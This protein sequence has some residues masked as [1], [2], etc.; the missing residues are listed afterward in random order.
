MAQFPQLVAVH[1]KNYFDFARLSIV[2][3]AFPGGY[4]ESLQGRTGGNSQHADFRGEILT[5]QKKAS[6]AP[7]EEVLAE[8]RIR[9][10][11]DA[12]IDQIAAGE[13]VERPASVV[14]ELV[15]NALDA[16]A[17]RIRVELREG[18]NDFIAV[19]DDGLGMAADE[20]RM[21]LRRHATSKIA[22]LDDLERIGSFG[23][24]GEAL[25]A[26]AS[27]SRMRLLSRRRDADVGHEL[28]IEAGEVTRDREAGCPV[29]T[30]IEVA[31]LFGQI[32]ARRKFLKKPATEWG[33]AYDW[34]M[35]LALSLPGV[36]FEVIREDREVGVWPATSDPFAR[37]GAVLGNELAS[38]LLPVNWEERAGHI[39]AWVSSPDL[40]RA[41]AQSLYLYV[42]GRPV[43]DRL[44]RHA[45]LE[46]YR[47]WLPRGRYPVVVLALTVDP[48]EVDVNV[49]P[50]KWEVRFTQP[51]AIHALVRQAIR[52][53]M[54][55]RD[56]LISG[57]PS[58]DHDS[59][60]SGRNSGS[61]GPIRGES[62]SPRTSAWVA[63]GAS[64]RPS[65]GRT[66][67][68]FAG[69]RGSNTTDQEAEARAN[70]GDPL[71]GGLAL[72][73]LPLLGQMLASYLLLEAEDGLILVDQHAAH[74][75][76]LYERLRSSWLDGSVSR[77]GLLM[78]V[79]VE[80]DPLAVAALEDERELVLGL[81]FEVEPFGEGAV[82]VRAIPALL[83]GQ[84]P[85]QLIQDLA[86][87]LSSSE[88]GAG[89][90]AGSQPDR[91]STR[92]LAVI[93]RLFATLACH[94]ARRFG[95]HLPTEEQR[96]ILEGLDSIPWAQTCPHG[97][98]VA[99]RISR[100]EIERRFGRS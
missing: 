78:G 83:S 52:E 25:P 28:R 70:Q 29:G 4:F 94:S 22:E 67:W 88:S 15:E 23:F 72:S 48:A 58:S 63:E 84:D 47:D 7:P 27:V 35:R 80:L 92:L 57:H 76:V 43:R 5:D 66:D 49:H 85:G 89:Q 61:G 19:V 82:V 86:S 12:L 34:L 17:R 11:P 62:P 59:S 56:H 71:E 8:S 98:P 75:R 60:P 99:R 6:I 81:G 68:L 42:N 40:T 1:Q 44:L 95:D 38:C 51:R 41:N 21:A 39:E 18:G 64:E 91:S 30:R 100:G 3:A 31:N 36:H 93:D 69:D 96:A 65:E 20:A 16:N 32:P 24:R 73:S 45:V 55:G 26:M 54:S 79:T 87:E 33:H 10:L 2:F 97:R 77:Q 14:K 74:E 50:A 13:V 53:A 9:L 37:I 46:S 90:E